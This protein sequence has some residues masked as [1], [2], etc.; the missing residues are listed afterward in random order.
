MSQFSPHP[1]NFHWHLQNFNDLYPDLV[2]DWFEGMIAVLDLESHFQLANGAAWEDIYLSPEEIEGKRLAEIFSG[3]AYHQLRKAYETALEGKEADCV[4]FQWLNH[5]YLA[6]SAPFYNA[7]DDLVGVILIAKDTTQQKLVERVNAERQSLLQSFYHQNQMMMGVVEI[8]PNDIRHLSDNQ[9]TAQFFRR[10]PEEM[11]GKTAREMGVPDVILQRWLQA[12]HECLQQQTMISFDYY[13]VFDSTE[14]DHH[15]SGNWL[16]VTVS[17]LKLETPESCPRCSYLVQNIT[18]RK[19][20]ELALASQ[21]KILKHFSNSLKALHQLSTKYYNDFSTLFAEY[22]RVGCDIFG[23]EI[24]IVSK[25]NRNQYQI[26]AVHSQNEELA[27]ELGAGF[28]LKHTY[29]S[30][31]MRTQGTISDHQIGLDGTLNE[32][33]AYQRF[34]L[35]SYIGTPIF[36]KNEIYGTLNFSATKTREKSF[37]DHEREIIELMAHDLGKLIAARRAEL[38]RRKVENALKAQLKRSHL[39]KSITTEIRSKLDLNEISKSTAQKLGES[40]KVDR[41]YIYILRETDQEKEIPFVAEYLSENCSSFKHL[42]IPIRENAHLERVLKR[43]RAVSSPNVYQDPLLK[44]MSA[45]CEKINLKSML[46]VRTSYQNCP[47]GLIGLHQCDYYRQWTEEEIKLLEDVAEQVGVAIAQAQLLEEKNAQNEALEEAKALAETANQAKSEFLATM[48]HEIRTPMN[49]IIGMSELLL[50]TALNEEQKDFVQTIYGSGNTLL[51]IINDILDFSKIESGKLE[52]EN[53]EFSLRICIENALDLVTQQAAQKNLELAYWLDPNLPTMIEGDEMRLQQVFVNLL[54]NAV[55][56]TE[57]G[58]IIVIATRQNDQQMQFCVSDTGIGIPPDKID[59]LFQSFTQIDASR[60][61]RI[62]GTGLGLAISKRLCTLMGGQMWAFSQG[63]VAGTPPTLWHPED[64]LFP[65]FQNSN[66]SSFYFT[67]PCPQG[68]TPPTFSL[69]QGKRVLIVEESVLNTSVLSLQIRHWGMFPHCVNSVEAALVALDT[70]PAFDIA[71]IS[72]NSPAVA[73]NFIQN[74]RSRLSH[75]AL[76]LIALTPLKEGTEVITEGDF[77][78]KLQKPVKQSRLYNTFINY[79]SDVSGELFEEESETDIECH[80]PYLPSLRILVAEDNPVNQKVVTKVLQRLG[81]SP[82]VVNNGL[83]AIAAVETEDYDIILMDLHMPEMDGLEA[84][85]KILTLTQKPPCIVAMTADVS[86]EVQ[87]ECVAM[88]MNAYLSKPVRSSAL[89]EVL[90][91]CY[92]HQG[93]STAVKVESPLDVQ[94]FQNLLSAIGEDDS[95]AIVEILESYLEDFP[96]LVEKIVRSAEAET[97][98]ELV[99]AVHTLKGT[100]A[101]MGALK[102]RDRC[103]EIQNLVERGNSPSQD[104]IEQLQQ[105]SE[106]VAQAIS[107]KI[108]QLTINN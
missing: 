81:Y 57:E 19:E 35:E 47:N 92:S 101:V 8:L 6:N 39:L 21:S 91:K 73:S 17:P 64:G 78:A 16:S 24:G 44:P 88:G 99:T 32:H 98:S 42:L 50:D 63:H 7:G 82:D 105:E 58:E 53:Q 40:F 10:S 94:A 29:C 37:Q 86:Q 85:E 33:P 77:I 48:S 49:A 18:A 20:I 51:S 56:F 106:R 9:A 52:L 46:A 31:V 97:L 14:S 59:R 68:E 104:R 84:T 96:K 4:E 28:D 71:I 27:L 54:S 23:L 66:G 74:I 55:K 79:F 34:K 65:Q 2:R 70:E 25:I 62:Q 103:Q 72:I 5:T 93:H 102:L 30:E 45:I 87:E 107:H 41:C 61:R 15:Q 89:A 38:K 43:D 22:L 80:S 83:E 60:S 69:L 13:H 12:Y 108:K 90:Q 100:S 76:P 67:L 3:E 75:Q 36:V 95:A 11:Q 26:V 1:K